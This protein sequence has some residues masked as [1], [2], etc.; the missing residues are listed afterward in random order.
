MS[1]RLLEVLLTL[2]VI[3]EDAYAQRSEWLNDLFPKNS[4]RFRC[5]CRHEN[6]FALRQQVPKQIRNR[7]SF[8]CTWR[9][10]NQDAFASSQL[11][12]DLQL[13]LVGGLAQQNFFVFVA[14]GDR[15]GIIL[16]RARSCAGQANDL[17]KRGR[18]IDALGNVLQNKVEDTP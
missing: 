2:L 12:R 17:K 10:L 7:V 13:F 16:R 3:L 4:K 9:P 14:E 11:P 8:T 18:E 1:N 6:A 15:S 5:V